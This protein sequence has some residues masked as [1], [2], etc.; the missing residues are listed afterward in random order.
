[1]IIQILGLIATSAYLGIL[2]GLGGAAGAGVPSTSP[3]GDQSQ[4]ICRSC[5]ETDVTGVVP[6]SDR[7]PEWIIGTWVLDSAEVKF[8]MVLSP[9]GYGRMTL[10]GRLLTC[11]YEIYGDTLIV[12][13][14]D[15][16]IHFRL[17]AAKKAIYTAGEAELKKK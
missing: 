16:P 1:M 17:D 3:D 6:A 14:N 4:A 2:S 7:I 12:T 5:E 11:T 9:K 15:V 13:R 10:L 8:E